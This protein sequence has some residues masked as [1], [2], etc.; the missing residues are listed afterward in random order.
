[1][2]KKFTNLIFSQHSGFTLVEMAVTLVIMGLII[3]TLLGPL[4]AQ[5][6]MKN[7]SGTQESLN[8][9]KEALNGFAILNGRLPCPTNQ[10]DPANA[11]YGLEDCSIVTEGYLPWKTLGVNESD[12]WG[13]H[14]NSVTDSWNGYWRYR[15]DGN[16]VTT[17]LFNTNILA[18]VPAF[19]NNLLIKDSNSNDVTPSAVG[20]EK[21]I[22]IVYSTGKDLVANG[23]NSGAV[24]AVYES[25]TINS[26][27][28]DMLI[29][30]T[31]PIIVN[32]MVIAGKLPQ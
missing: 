9:I 25:D 11:S 27:F 7:I 10:A 15:A 26:N 17:I 28:D 22:A 3:S 12:E 2:K 5:R 24:D 32:R 31:R 13:Q 23:Q 29:W 6:D 4:S 1:M 18:P 21:P 20:T 8:Q 16:Y 14:R 19:A 30:I